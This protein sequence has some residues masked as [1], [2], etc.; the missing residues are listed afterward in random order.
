M[1]ITRFSTSYT[2]LK[3]MIIATNL[4]KAIVCLAWYEGNEVG[5]DMMS[6]RLP[7]KTSNLIC[8][9]EVDLKCKKAVL[10]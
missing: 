5:L 9:E 3:I 8:P 2:V 7:T 1:K 4:R 6:L 10:H